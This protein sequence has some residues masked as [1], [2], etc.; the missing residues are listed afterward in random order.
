MQMR[1][2]LPDGLDEKVKFASDA[3]GFD[4]REI[5]ERAII[6]YLD[7]I[8]KQLALK[9]EFEAW[10]TLSNEALANFEATL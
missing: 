9:N 4:E 7:T 3:L 8:E 5:I 6:F 2:K 1:I 10:D